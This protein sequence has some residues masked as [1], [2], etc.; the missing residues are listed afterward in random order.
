MHQEVREKKEMHR[1][2][3][4]RRGGSEGK[5]TVCFI[6]LTASASSSFCLLARFLFLSLSLP[7]LSPCVSG[8]RDGLGWIKPQVT[9][10]EH[11]VMRFSHLH[12]LHMKLDNKDSCCKRRRDKMLKVKWAISLHDEERKASEA[13][14]TLSLHMQVFVCHNESLEEAVHWSQ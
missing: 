11:E 5:S 8:S 9:R 12:L 10:D 2:R 14:W 1:E 3:E 13:T 6:W 4:E 7:F